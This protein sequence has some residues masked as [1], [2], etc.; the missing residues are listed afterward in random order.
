MF[1][2]NF[3]K[4]I[5]IFGMFIFNF[6][7]VIFIFGPQGHTSQNTPIT[8]T[9]KLGLSCAKL[10]LTFYLLII[11]LLAYWPS[12]LLDLLFNYLIARIAQIAWIA[13][14]TK[15]DRIARCARTVLITLFVRIAQ[16]SHI[17]WFVQIAWIA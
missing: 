4:V 11:W 6:C 2:F 7:K 5:F 14:F 17:A 13:W 15:L 10:R 8:P 16:I 12:C 3:C 9:D 1:I